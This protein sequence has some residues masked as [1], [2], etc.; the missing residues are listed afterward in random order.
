MT[1]SNYYDVTSRKEAA[2]KHQLQNMEPNL[3]P[4]LAADHQNNFQQLQTD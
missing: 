1:T 4:T 3:A 2:G